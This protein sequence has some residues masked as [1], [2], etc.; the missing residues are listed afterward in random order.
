[1]I[2]SLYGWEGSAACRVMGETTSGVRTNKPM[3]RDSVFLLKR[4]VLLLLGDSWSPVCSGS[5]PGP[6]GRPSLPWSPRVDDLHIPLLEPEI[7]WSSD[8]SVLGW[9]WGPY[10][11][12]IG[13]VAPFPIFPLLFPTAKSAL[14]NQFIFH[15]SVDRIKCLCLSLLCLLF[16]GILSFS[17]PS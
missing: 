14:W 17:F 15:T 7:W 11:N 12:N 10:L 1:M 4:K 2:P 8:W 6:E 3:M 9:G 16:F 13:V 5:G